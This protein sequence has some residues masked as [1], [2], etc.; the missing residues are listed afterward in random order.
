MPSG[1]GDHGII[2]TNTPDVLNEEVAIRRS[3][4][5]FALCVNFHNRALLAR[6]QMAAGTLSAHQGDAARSHRRDG[7]QWVAI[8]KAIAGV[9]RR[10]A[11][12]VV[13][14]SRNPQRA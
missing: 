13:Y 4:S 2:V 8:G 5:C 7:R 10:S 1:P 3:A 12:P 9:S 14:H 6:R 11:V